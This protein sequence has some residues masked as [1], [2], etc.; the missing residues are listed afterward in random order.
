M[1]YKMSVASEKELRRAINNF[2]AKVK[3]LENVDKEIDIPRKENIKAIMDRISS[4]WDLNREIDKLQRFSKRN[5]E[6]L[7]QNKSGV[8]M[9]RWEYENLQREQRRLS[10]RLEREIKSYGSI[11]PTIFGEKQNFSYVQMGDERLSNLK[12]R[13]SAIARR[14]G[15]ST[16]NKDEMDAL[17][18][19]M[20]KTAAIFRRD[21]AIFFDNYLDGTLLNLSYQTGYDEEKIKY[22]REKLS[23]LTSSQFIKAFNSEAGL[24]DIQDR[25]IISKEKGVKVEDIS[26]DVNLILDELYKNIDQIV[27]DYK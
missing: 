23:T 16:L 26:Q 6:E 27:K 25:Y 20:S 3:R 14:G 19:V 11:K 9:S 12:A 15:I 21:R 1:A 2:N 17:K 7:I 13:R 4:K 24:K 22:I 10:A 18:N 5:A 8:V